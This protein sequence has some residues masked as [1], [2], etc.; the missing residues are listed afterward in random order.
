MAVKRLIRRDA[1]PRFL[2]QTRKAGRIIATAF[3][4]ILPLLSGCNGCK[5]EQSS[6]AQTASEQARKPPIKAKKSLTIDFMLH[7]TDKRAACDLP[8]VLSSTD[9]DIIFLE[10]ANVTHEMAA[11]LAPFLNHEPTDKRQLDFGSP[12]DPY[13]VAH[14]FTKSRHSTKIHFAESHSAEEIAQNKGKVSKAESLSR[15]AQI[16]YDQGR[17]EDAIRLR[18]Q[19]CRERAKEVKVRNDRIVATITETDFRNGVLSVGGLHENLV[20]LLREAGIEVSVAKKL[21][22]PSDLTK[23]YE[24]QL[25]GWDVEPINED[26]EALRYLTC[27]RLSIEYMMRGF[28]NLYDAMVIVNG[29][30]PRS[31]SED[32]LRE[33]YAQKYFAGASM[34]NNL[35]AIGIELPR[36]REAY[37]QAL[38]DAGIRDCR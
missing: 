18:K 17:L 4:S 8:Q 35:A 12:V 34:T 30:I 10:G 6:D 31:T 27:A 38:K 19:S 2:E 16:A 20:R 37:S 15:D 11:E 22:Y 28:G 5:T 32:F 9:P 3:V 21:D 36:T 7:D 1:S 25:R 24:A 26:L 29:L 14:N 33:V 13:R 23:Y